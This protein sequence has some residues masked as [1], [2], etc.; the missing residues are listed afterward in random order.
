MKYSAISLPAGKQNLDRYFAD[1]EKDLYA[2]CD[3]VSA[4][5]EFSQLFVDL[6]VQ[7]IQ[8]SASRFHYSVQETEEFL[9]GFIETANREIPRRISE[10]Y[11]HRLNTYAVGAGS[12]LAAIRYVDS[13]WVCANLGIARLFW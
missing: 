11:G 6:L 10:R 4:G 1:Q 3:G 5:G 9:A 13:N 7:D 8:E 12:T 2:V